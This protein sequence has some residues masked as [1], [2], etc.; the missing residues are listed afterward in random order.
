VADTDDQRQLQPQRLE[1]DKRRW[2][3]NG[4]E[5]VADADEPRLERWLRESLLECAD[6]RLAWESGSSSDADSEPAI[7]PAIPW[8]ERGQWLI[9]PDVG[10]VANG[11]PRRMDRLK[12]L[13]NAVVPK[14]PK[15]IGDAIMRSRLNIT[16]T[17]GSTK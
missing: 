6:E 3:G 11:V 15:I 13:G 1:R 10:R 9:E 17:V 4:S 5:D 8:G 7:G 14:V 2:L 16:T 12:Q